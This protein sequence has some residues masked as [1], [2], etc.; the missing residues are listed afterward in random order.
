ML[1]I[2]W[3]DIRDVYYREQSQLLNTG[4]F[5]LFISSLNSISN[6]CPNPVH[7]N[8]SPILN[9]AALS[10]YLSHLLLIL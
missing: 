5:S 7:S 4:L 9:A 2:L 10:M 1:A 3:A 8:L 6:Q